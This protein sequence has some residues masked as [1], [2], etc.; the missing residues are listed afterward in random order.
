MNV[1]F[2]DL[3]AQYLSIKKEIDQAIATT[4]KN[5]AYIGGQAVKDFETAFAGYLGIG[6]VIACANG[7]DS[8][9]MLLKAY[10]I[11]EGDEVIVPA[12]SWISTSEAVSS[13]GAT[14]VF[15]D[16]DED[17]FTIDPVQLEKA[18]SSRT[19][20][21]IPVHLYGQPADM[22]AIMQVATAH[23]LVVIEDC[24]QAHGARIGGKTA[25]TWGH[26]SSFS[27]YPGKNL[28]AYGDA[29]CMATDDPAI[30]EKVR[31]ISQHGQKGKHN[32]IMEGRNSRL[33]GLQAAILLAKLPYL[34]KWTEARIAH[35]KTYDSLLRDVD[36]TTPPARR[37]ARHVFHLYVIR[38]ADRDRVQKSLSDAGVE[39]AIHYPTALPFLPC[40]SH[41]NFTPGHFPVAYS[42]QNS[43]LSL[44][45]YPEMQDSAIQYVC[46]VLKKEL[47]W[48]KA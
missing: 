46:G 18:V 17:Y 44:P 10:G 13:V 16:I 43:I 32:H 42:C 28:G 36:L 9:E 33:D 1:P 15:A 25:G 23:G 5:S 41:R 47:S 4:I 24:A 11:G 3:Y 6:H 19:R 8:I 21:I 39:T 35:T 12:I 26:A 30:A 14:P 38:T 37:D 29:G 20:A 34:E 27:F 45:L 48:I 22:P 40:Y 7:T 2:A 31:M